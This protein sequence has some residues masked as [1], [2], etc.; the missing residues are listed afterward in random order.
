[1]MAGAK[2]D[3]IIC[4]LHRYAEDAVLLAQFR[5]KKPTPICVCQYEDLAKRLDVLMKS[6]LQQQ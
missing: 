4:P 6:E 5:K 2:S 1:M 3:L